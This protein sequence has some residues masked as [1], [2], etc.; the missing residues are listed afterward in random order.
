MGHVV[1]DIEKYGRAV[2]V[3]EMS[4]QEAVSALVAARGGGLTPLGATDLLANWK[5]ARSEYTKVHEDF[6]ETRR[7]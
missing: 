2:E 3:G 4:S 5:T 7:S 1:D 6:D